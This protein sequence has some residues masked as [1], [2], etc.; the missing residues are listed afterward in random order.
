[1]YSYNVRLFCHEKRVGSVRIQQTESILFRPPVSYTHLEKYGSYILSFNGGMI[2]DCK[3]GEAVFQRM[4]P[5]ESNEKIIRLS[6][7]ERV[8]ILTY[9]SDGRILYTNQADSP[10]AQ[11]EQRINHMEI[12][13]VDDMACLL[14][15]SSEIQR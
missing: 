3:T 13:Q 4:L 2:T 8:G 11:L 9:S 7:E 10:Y 12:E 6:E 1:M 5:L 14:Y 15:T